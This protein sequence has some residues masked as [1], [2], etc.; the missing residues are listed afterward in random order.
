MKL[1]GAKNRIG[2]PA[3]KT[4]DKKEAKALNIAT[5]LGK[6]GPPGEKC[7][8]DLT[9][10]PFL[11]PLGPLDLRPCDEV[12]LGFAPFPQHEGFLDA[13]H[14]RW[15][16]DDAARDAGEAGDDEAAQR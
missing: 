8:L 11:L 3:N 1:E 6:P 9:P 15:L 5:F 4:V 2:Q 13:Q 7:A 16:G 14:C 12:K 10:G